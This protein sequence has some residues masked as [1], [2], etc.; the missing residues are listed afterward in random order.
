M[1]KT[2]KQGN[3][4]FVMESPTWGRRDV[5]GGTGTY[6]RWSVLG[7]SLKE[8]IYELGSDKRDIGSRAKIWEKI[9]VKPQHRYLAQ[10]RIQLKQNEEQS[11]IQEGS[12]KGVHEGS[13]GP[14]YGVLLLPDV[15]YRSYKT[16]S[17]CFRF[18]KILVLAILEGVPRKRNT[19][20]WMECF[21]DILQTSK[22]VSGADFTDE[23]MEVPPPGP[24]LPSRLSDAVVVSK[25]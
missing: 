12:D 6:P 14:G 3:R 16:T 19:Q 8:A 9:R 1:I 5:G 22:P 21:Q 18:T 10:S 11:R 20:G 15:L 23:G 4:G 13:G 2:G 17:N 24:P 25:P 7:R